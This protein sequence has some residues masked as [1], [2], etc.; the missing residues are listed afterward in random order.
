V[1]LQM[2]GS[3]NTEDEARDQLDYFRSA[4]RVMLQNHDCFIDCLLLIFTCNCT[5]WSDWDALER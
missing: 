2:M 1:H 3:T 5:V 4:C